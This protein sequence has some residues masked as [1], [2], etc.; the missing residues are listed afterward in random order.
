M[1]IVSTTDLL[2]SCDVDVVAGLDGT[3]TYDVILRIRRGLSA[4]EAVLIHDQL[5]ND[6]APAIG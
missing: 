5:T 1:D 2:R 4:E 3:D 6:K